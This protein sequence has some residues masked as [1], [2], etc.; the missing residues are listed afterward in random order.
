[1]VPPTRIEAANIG[2]VLRQL[3]AIF[4]EHSDGHHLRVEVQ[5]A[6]A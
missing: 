1:M 4:K 2:G 6:R 5:P 3:E